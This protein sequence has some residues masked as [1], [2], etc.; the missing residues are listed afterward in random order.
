MNPTHKSQSTPRVHDGIRLGH[1]VSYV[2]LIIAGLL[3]I[4]TLS[5]L[6]IKIHQMPP[7][8]P[9][10]TTGIISF[11]AGC[12]LSTETINMWINSTQNANQIGT[13]G[14]NSV[15]IAQFTNSL[16]TCSYNGLLYVNGKLE[17]N[18][19][20]SGTTPT[21][22]TFSGLE[23]A[24]L[25]TIV[26]N[27]T[28]T[29]TSET[30]SQ[31]INKAVP[32][33]TL[34]A[35]RA[36][37]TYNG[38]TENIS[39]SV[40]SVNSQ[41]SGSLYINGLLESSLYK[42]ATAGIWSAWFNT[43]A[44]QNYSA[45]QSHIARQIYQASPTL[46]LTPSIANFTYNG[47]AEKFTGTV[48][49]IN[50]QLIAKLYINGVSK[51]NPYSNA[52]AGVFDA[53]YNTSGDVNYTSGAAS[54]SRTISKATI[55]QSLSS[56]PSSPF[57]YDGSVPTITDT[58][59]GTLVSGQSG[60]SFTLDNNSVSTGSTG[61][62]TLSSSSFSFSALNGKYAAAGSYSYMSTSSGNG[63]YTVVTSSPLSVTITQAAPVITLTS[64]PSANFT[65]NG[66]DLVFHFSI[67]SINS[68]LGGNFYINGSL[69]N[70]SITTNGTYNAGDLPN[71]FVG[72][73]NT[74][75]DHNYSSSS[76]TLSRQIYRVIL[77]LYLNGALDSN[78]N[79]TQGTE[80]NFTAMISPS[81]DYVGIYENGNLVASSKGNLTYLKTLSPGVYKVVAASNITGVSN[82]TYYERI[83]GNYDGAGI[84]I[85]PKISNKISLGI[86]RFDASTNYLSIFP[87]VYLSSSDFN[88]I[89]ILFTPI[90][91]NI[92]FSLGM[93]VNPNSS[94]CDVNSVKDPVQGINLLP[95]ISENGVI[96]GANFVFSLKLDSEG[97]IPKYN[98]SPY[99]VVLYKCDEQN[100][101]W[102]ELP[103]NTSVS[104]TGIATYSAN[105]NSLSTYEIG[106]FTP[107]KP[108][109]I[110]TTISESGLPSGYTWNVTYDGITKSSITPNNIIF[111]TAPG[112]YSFTAYNFTFSPSPSNTGCAIT[113]Y[114]SNFKAGL[115]QSIAAGSYVSVMYSAN[116]TI[117]SSAPVLS[118]TESYCIVYAIVIIAVIALA[119]ALR[120]KLQRD[121]SRQ[122]KNKH[123]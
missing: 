77:Q 86:G 38:T 12:A 97:M 85:F 108:S 106:A 80:S 61:S 34:T 78:K 55:T 60:L 62:S 82:I 122:K 52:T 100:S 67:S 20:I 4:L 2:W 48:T 65:Q 41:V 113:Y 3:I 75:G 120:K 7:H 71:I 99:D 43:T 93:E 104:Q 73:F 58:L 117:C 91:A 5:M 74:S 40:S 30:H 31:T 121:R 79:I 95:S 49:S 33:I 9:Q 57:A 88:K 107:A 115:P 102:I 6:L 46:T 35:T 26:A 83:I 87:S 109:V 47:T 116:G 112:N 36:N 27:Q 59:S 123:K 89:N 84:P 21:N 72:V 23:S 17:G 92:S 56:S 29:S 119:Y 45:A 8:V 42:N 44:N 25:Y 22:V 76:L 103:T 53:V 50:N 16:S 18:V 24:G 10:I 98:M 70:S 114:P 1:A 15:Y 64:T 14:T 39:G 32:T 63:N 118:A 105:S 81:T 101:S 19:S 11:S 68:Q 90:A 37:F 51:T 28:A 111:S 66:T 13:Y 54:R 69:K 94:Q 96:R 110:N